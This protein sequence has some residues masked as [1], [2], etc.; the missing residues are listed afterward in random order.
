MP[1]HSSWRLSVSDQR[2]RGVLPSRVVPTPPV[3]RTIPL[4]YRLADDEYRAIRDG[5]AIDRVEPRMLARVEDSAMIDRLDAVV[6]WRD[7]TPRSC[8][9]GGVVRADGL[10]TGLVSVVRERPDRVLVDASNATVAAFL[11]EQA[12]RVTPLADTVVRVRLR[13]PRTGELLR[14]VVVGDPPALIPGTVA[15]QTLIVDQPAVTCC[16][17]PDRFAVYCERAAARRIW[18]ALTAA[19]AIATGSVALETVR[20]EDGEPCLERDFTNPVAPATAGFGDLAA[21]TAPHDR[22]VLIEH[23]GSSPLAAA[24]IRRDGDEIGQ[25]RV[26]ARSPRRAGRPVALCV[27]REPVAVD[28]AVTVDAGEAVFA[29]VVTRLAAL[30]AA[31]QA[32]NY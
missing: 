4:A 20:I 31:C 2:G 26:A 3:I 18:D 21:A 13:G 19:G 17:G 15:V 9:L 23:A 24:T 8:R 16:T 27:L 14:S 5:C 22:L 32:P 11:D 6:S 10:L 30:P 12:V 1:P 29:G 28:Q 7:A 25:V